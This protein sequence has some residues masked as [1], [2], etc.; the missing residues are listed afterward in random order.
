MIFKKGAHGKLNKMEGVAPLFRREERKTKT[1]FFSLSHGKLIRREERKYDN[2]FDGLWII[3]NEYNISALYDVAYE[4]LEDK[5]RDILRMSTVVRIRS[6]FKRLGIRKV[7]GL[8]K[9]ELIDA[10]ISWGKKQRGREGELRRI[11][12]AK[13]I[14]LANDLGVGVEIPVDIDKVIKETLEAID[15]RNID[16]CWVYEI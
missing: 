11:D 2:K 3:V 14:K 6:I 12:R 15:T 7:S 9:H 8:K 4:D 13:L 1:T 16:W 10:V 5:L